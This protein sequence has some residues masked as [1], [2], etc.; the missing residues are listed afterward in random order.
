MKRRFAIL[1][2]LAVLTVGSTP[3]QAGADDHDR[4]L[5]VIVAFG[6]GLNTAQPGNP[7]NH[8]IL[9]PTIRIKRG[10]VVNFAVA[11]FHQIYVYN[12]GKLPSQ[13]AVPATG[14]FIN[15]KNGLYYEGIAPQGGPAAT[16][17]TRNPLND[18]NRMEPVSFAVDG[19]YLVICNVRGH[20]L[21]G[22][23]AWVVVG[24]DDDHDGD[25][26]GGDDH[27]DHH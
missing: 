21:D 24:D 4:S 9:P 10:G 12:P 25:H 2:A 5:S 3:G 7:A 22:M 26:G 18:S 19:K 1:V 27:S 6:A 16:P 14:T 20:F 15:D 13:V 17:A 8:H 23:M 11:G